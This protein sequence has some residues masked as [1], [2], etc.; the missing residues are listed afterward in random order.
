MREKLAADEKIQELV[1]EL[2]AV[3]RT[4]NK[5]RAEN[6]MVSSHKDFCKPGGLYSQEQSRSRSVFKT[7]RDFHDGRDRLLKVSRSRVSIETTSR[8]IDTPRL[9]VF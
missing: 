4:L 1:K 2:G 5:M 9:L 6:Y 3:E 8:Q 7:C